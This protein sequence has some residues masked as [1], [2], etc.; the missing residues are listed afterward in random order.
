MYKLKWNGV[1]IEEDIETLE[2][3]RELRIEYEI[4]YK[5]TVKVLKQ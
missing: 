4:A 5:G 2:E 3:A 1:I